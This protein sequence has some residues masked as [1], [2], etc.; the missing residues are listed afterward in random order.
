MT[1]YSCTLTLSLVSLAAAAVL[2][3]AQTTPAAAAASQPAS[4]VENWIKDA[5]NPVSWLTWGG[6]L[7]IRNEYYDNIVSLSGGVA[8][9]EQDVIRYRGRVWASAVPIQD[10]SLNVRV[11]AEPRE[12][13]KPAFVSA[14]KGETGMEWRYGV[15]DVLNL[16][17]T[18]I[19]QQ[20]LSLTAGRQD[21]MFG[22]Y[23]DWWLV[24]DGTPGDGSW[25]F[26]LDGVRLT[27]DSRDLKTKFDAMYIYQNA[28][29]GKWVP[30]IGR[31]AYKGG[32]TSD[33]PIT[34]QR[35]RG[36]VF[37]VSNKSIEKTQLDGYFILKHDDPQTF[38]YGATA[39]TPGDKGDIYT[40]GAKVTGTPAEHWQYSAEGAYQF[41]NK[42][43]TVSGTL[44]KR[45]ISAYGGKAKLTYLCKDERKNQLSLI[46]EFMSGDDPK[47]ANKDEMFDVLW[48][49]WPRWS[50]LYIY[51]YIYETSGKI[52]QMNNLLRVGPAWSVVPVKN[53]SFSAMY[54]AM[55]APESTPT[56]TVAAPLF[57]NNGNFRGHYVQGILKYQL[58][59][60]AAAHLWGEFVWQ[61]DYYT[62]RD[63]L[64][65]LRGEVMFT[66]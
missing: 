9:H 8:L 42:W 50:E 16:K 52:A 56:R 6:D 30:T 46:G 54:N 59:K 63:L 11:S 29:P 14:Y 44:A 24:L 28:M 38:H 45:D 47:T 22:D 21:V 62:H 25:A 53:L 32:T 15:F 36:L 2:A 57:T 27:Y 7:R 43:D 5:K 58:G 20:P 49:R 10:I 17:W 26:W 37:Y 66:F 65:F 51:S 34:D 23:Y 18:N 3:Q 48:G 40:V 12:W 60:H 39:K 35:E 13:M 31:S 55:F 33:Y 19:L 64:S 41:G 4:P 1:R 61:G